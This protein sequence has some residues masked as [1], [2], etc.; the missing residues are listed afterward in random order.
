M[1][2][3][4]P[5]KGLLVFAIFLNVLFYACLDPMKVGGD[6][7]NSLSPEEIS[8]L[9][10]GLNGIILFLVGIAMLSPQEKLKVWYRR[11]AVREE[12]YLAE[13]G[14]PWPWLMPAAVMAYVLLVAEAAGFERGG[15]LRDWRLGTAGVQLFVVLVF[16]TRDVL[17]LQWCNLTR[18]KRSVVKGFL[19]ICLYY[20]AAGILAA[21]VG[22]VTHRDLLLGILTPF[23]VFSA[24]IV[25]PRA[26]PSIYIGIVLQIAVVLFLLKA[27]STRLRRPAIIP[28]ASA[29]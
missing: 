26:A 9:A 20:M 17:F 18:M 21:V 4:M 23:D 6:R 24:R 22:G 12:R 1:Y 5:L 2:A 16:I 28:A 19:Y 27:I 25:A 7:Y 15:S 10:M 8:A 29:A 11:F 3:G 14:P 13:Y